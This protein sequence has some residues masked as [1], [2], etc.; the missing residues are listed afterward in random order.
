MTYLSTQEVAGLI[1]VTETTI[2]R[3]ADEGKIPCHKTL[4]GH[5]KFLMKEIVQFAEDNA[6]PLSGTVAPPL[7]TRGARGLELAIQTKDYTILGQLFYVEALQAE[8]QGIYDL[9]SYLCKHHISLPVLADEVI[10][11]AMARIGEEWRS[12]KLDVN[13]EHLASN[14]VLEALIHLHPELHRKPSHGLSA[15][16]ACAEGNYHELGLRLFAYALETEGWKVHYL[17]ANTPF[18]TLRSFMK[19]SRPDLICLSATII[20]RKISSMSSFRAIGKAARAMKAIYLVGGSMSNGYSIDYF[21]CDYITDSVREAVVFL[22]NH[23]Q[24]KPGPKTR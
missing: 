24:L 13:R 2:K 8:R 19:N 15:V 16:C 7:D 4:G 17:G 11:P 14:A 22:K 1:N 3:W 10:K 6:Y 21:K 18:L 12:G 5:R 20:D 23:F 9:L